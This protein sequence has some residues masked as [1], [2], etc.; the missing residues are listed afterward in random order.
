MKKTYFK[1]LNFDLDTHQ[2]KKYY[3]KTNYRQSYDDLRKFF[4][5]HNFSHRQGSGYL[6]DTK[7]NASDIYDMMEE[8]SQQLPWIRGCVSKMDVTDVG[9]QYDLIEFL[10]LTIPSEIT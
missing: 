7:L 2:L 1:A 5:C 10:H 3:S 6:S 4:K 8:L 9:P